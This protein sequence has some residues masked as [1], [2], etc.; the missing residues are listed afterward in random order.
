L[1]WLPEAVRVLRG[2]LPNIEIV[3]SSETSPELAGIIRQI[4]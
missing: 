4:A 2:E 1:D 3:I